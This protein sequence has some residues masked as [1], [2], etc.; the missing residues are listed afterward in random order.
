[1][2][3]QFLPASEADIPFIYDQAKLLID[4]YEDI[5]SI[6]YEKVLGWVK[7]KIEKEIPSYCRV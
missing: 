1:M 6:D 7:G 3:L 2:N 4:T 5:T